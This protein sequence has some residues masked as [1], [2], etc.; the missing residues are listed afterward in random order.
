MYGMIHKAAREFTIQQHGEDRWRAIL[1]RTDLSDEHFISGQHYSDDATLS[2]IGAIAEDLQID[3]GD[4]LRAFGQY[5]IRYTATTDYAAALQ[6]CGDDLVTFL[7]NLDDLH[8]GIKTTMPEAQLPSFSVLQADD[9]RIE[10]LYQSERQG[11]ASF[12]SG[13]LTGLMDKFSETGAIS[14]REDGEDLIFTIA[15]GQPA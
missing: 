3:A 1:S 13:L 14:W 2:L 12:V 9:R 4:V 15:R 6:M 11:L 8:R 7:H 5:W 10:L